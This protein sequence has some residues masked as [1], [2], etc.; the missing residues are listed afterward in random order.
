MDKKLRT[1]IKGKFNLTPEQIAN[2][3]DNELDN[4]YERAM[5]MEEILAVESESEDE[6]SL[7]AD[8]VDYIHDGNF[9]K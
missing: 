4:L 2:M 1:F 8:F 7:A 9:K 6:V 3:N 5:A